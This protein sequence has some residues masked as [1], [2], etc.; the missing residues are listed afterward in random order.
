MAEVV[1]VAE[2]LCGAEL[3]TRGPTRC[4]RPRGHGGPHQHW[5]VAGGEA[6]AE[7]G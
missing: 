4:D 3:D 1:G 7:D 6:K 2:V 5:G